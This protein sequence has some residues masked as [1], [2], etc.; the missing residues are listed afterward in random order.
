MR[1]LATDKHEE[2]MY[3]GLATSEKLDAIY[4]LCIG[5]VA[6]VLASV[7][8]KDPP[9]GN[10]ETFSSF[11]HDAPFKG[12]AIKLVGTTFITWAIQS[13]FKASSK[14]ALIRFVNE[15][16]HELL[17]STSGSADSRPD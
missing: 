9:A 1:K 10:M 12:I 7:V 11:F 14:F 5:I 16:K 6:F 3:L 2:L 8:I 15:K 13:S 4:S 17:V